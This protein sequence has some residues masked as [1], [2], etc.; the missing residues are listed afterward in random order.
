VVVT[1]EQSGRSKDSGIEVATQ[2]TFLFTLSDRKITE[3]R[4]FMANRTPSKHPGRTNSSLHR[5][6]RAGY[7]LGTHRRRWPA[8][9][10]HTGLA[11]ER[12]DRSSMSRFG[13]W[14]RREGRRDDA[15]TAAT[16]LDLC[17]ECGEGFVYPVSWI[18]SGVADWWLHLRCGNCGTVRDVVAS[19]YAVEAFD[20]LL[21]GEMEMIEAAAERLERESFVLSADDFR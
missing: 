9:L 3:W 21:D 10:S 1:T 19:N 4:M 7:G 13:R 11:P 17:S 20:R 12:P 14:L 5:E 2:F 16:R 8:G 15:E 18:E 6:A